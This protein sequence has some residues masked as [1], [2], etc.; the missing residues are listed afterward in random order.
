MEKRTLVLDKFKPREY[1]IPIIEAIEEDGFKRA[2][3]VMPRRCL[4]GDTQIILHNGANKS[5]KDVKNGDKILSYNHK[6]NKLDLDIVE[7]VWNTGDKFVSTFK[8]SYFHDIDT[9]ED[10][11]FYTHSGYTNAGRLVNQST[12]YNYKGITSGLKEDELDYDPFQLGEDLPDDYKKIFDADHESIIQ[13]IYGLMVDNGNISYNTVT[14]FNKN[15]KLIDNVYWLFRKLGVI[16]TQPEFKDSLWFIYVS[17]DRNP[18]S[19]NGV[20][21]SSDIRKGHEF[22]SDTY[23]IMTRKNHNFFANGYLVHNSG[24]DIVA[25]NIAIRQLVRKVCTIFYVFPT[26]SQARKAI[27]DAIDMKGKRILDYIPEELIAHK[28]TQDMQIVLT[29]GSVLQ[30]VGSDKYDRLVGTNPYACIFSEYSIQDPRGFKFLAPALSAQGGWALFISCVSPST[31]IATSSGLKRIKDIS[32]SRKEYSK[33]NRK[34]YG[35]GGFHNASD[36]YY[37]GTV[38]TIKIG[39]A[40]GYQLEC[41][42]IHKIWNG[43]YWI[44]SVDLKVGDLIPIQYGQRV[45]GKGL[46]I[47]K[48]NIKLRKSNENPIDIT[49]IDFF[50]LLGLIHGDGS[51]DSRK[52]TITN[53]NDPFIHDFLLNNNFNR[54]GKDLIHFSY[55]STRFCALLGF[56]GFKHGA[57]NKEFPIKLLECNE[58]QLGNF[59]SGLFDSDGTSSISLGK[60]GFVKITSTNKS[61]IDTLQVVLLNFGIVTST[62]TEEKKPTL[63]VNSHSTIYNLEIYGYFAGVFYNT[64]GFRLKR[65][66]DNFNLVPKSVL[67]ESGNVYPVDVKKIRKGFPLSKFANPSRVSRRT[68]RN[69][70]SKHPD[71]YLSS[72]LDEK[73]FYSKVRSITESSSEVFDFVIPETHSFFSNGFISHNTPR[74]KNAF[75]DQY[76]VAKKS[77][78]WF[79]LRLT[80]DDTK[81][82]SKE[83][84]ARIIRDQ[85]MSEDLVQQEFMCSFDMGVDGAVYAKLIDKM[86]LEDRI[87]T[88]LYNPEFPV[89]TA[90]DLGVRKTDTTAIVFFQVINGLLYIID[91][92]ENFR[93]GLAHYAKMI[94]DKSYVYGYHFLP[95][96]GVN[97]EIGPGMTRKHQ[98]EQLGLTVFT[99]KILRDKMLGI[100]KVRVTLPIMYIDETR[101]DR[102]LKALENYHYTW[103]AKR[104]RYNDREPYHDWASNY[105]DSLLY[106]C[107]SFGIVRDEE[108]EKVDDDDYYDN[109]IGPRAIGY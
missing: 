47:S 62:N 66:Q 44:K 57:R 72:L 51:Y 7:E 70:V 26:Y 29:N 40:S 108:V 63:L 58:E 49:N 89:H 61:F 45:F 97:F 19:G 50:Y 95:H 79:A 81:H 39:L 100:E 84:I 32:S 86:R 67:I 46:D 5:I 28:R 48:F 3:V 64:I 53:K 82:V 83:E 18:K 59:I 13:F 98:L 35:L 22:M 99:T 104:E 74:G 96:D 106:C 68:I 87:G 36:F 65:K 20:Y 41:S 93:E 10:H 14:V 42:H 78:D 30:F 102:L 4:H 23:D 88:I 6:S 94:K 103:D 9:T 109:N 90:W 27:W 2:I 33:L 31:L 55:N 1:Q 101:C 77:P 25:L 34:I 80:L 91:S 21:F 56:L 92:Y 16:P 85:E 17:D 75:Y 71:K 60:R 12:L 105:C 54:Y 107:L 52:V 76:Q 24:K 38:P 37:G 11:E 69:I 8:S 15:K 73:F 43:S